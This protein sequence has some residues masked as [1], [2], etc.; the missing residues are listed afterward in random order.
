MQKHLKTCKSC[1]VKQE[2]SEYKID[3]INE[4]FTD[5]LTCLEKEKQKNIEKINW[6]NTAEERKRKRCR[7]YQKFRN[8]TDLLFK[9]KSRI[10][11]LIY[12]SIVQRKGYTKKSKAND[13]LGCSYEFFKEY[14]EAQFTLEMNWN[15]IHLD[16]IKP[17]AI[18]NTE[19]EVLILNH[20][21]NFQPLWW[22]DNIQKSNK[23]LIK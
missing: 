20:Y 23:I 13:I 16:H 7:E 3:E 17:L 15:N 21:T 22:R 8:N 2:L 19:E 5:C 4:C 11:N 12:L 9:L 10:R 14:I 1:N 6:K 18:A